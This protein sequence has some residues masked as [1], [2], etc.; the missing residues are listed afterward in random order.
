MGYLGMEENTLEAIDEDGWL[1]SGDIGWLDDKT[2]LTVTGRI[3][4]KVYALYFTNSRQSDCLMFRRVDYH[5][6]WRKHCTCAN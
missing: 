1:H 5:C 4:G 2:F 3:K 6:W